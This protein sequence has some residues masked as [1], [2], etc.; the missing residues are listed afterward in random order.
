VHYEVGERT[1]AISQGGIGAV[2]QVA[3]QSGLVSR[4]NQ[5]LHV[6]K[7]HQPYHESDHVLNIAYNIFC[8]GQT[9]D[10]IE[11]RRNDEVYL[12]AL[13][14]MSIPDPTTAGDYCRRFDAERIET[15]TDLVNETRLNVWRRQGPGFTVQTARIDV[16]GSIVPTT[17]ECKEGMGLSYDGTWG[18]HPLLVSL[19]NTSE[20]LFIA[21]RSGNRPSNDGA[22]GYLNRAILLCRRA[23]FVDILL[24]GDTD[25]SQC[26]H[27]DGWTNDGVR[28]VFGYDAKKN[29]KTIA[30]NIDDSEYSRLVRK[31]EEAFEQ[32]AHQPRVKEAFVLAKGYQNLRLRSEEYAEF[33]YRP[34][35][36]RRTYR[37]VVVRK[38]ITVARGEQALFDEIRY[39]FYITNDNDLAARKV[40]KEAND[41]C[42]QENL[43]A[44]LK[45]GVRALHAPLNTL[46]ANWAY[47]V[48]VSLSWSLKAWM[49]LWLPISRRWA[50]QH[51]AQRDAWL[52]MEFRTFCNAVINIPA[53]IVRTGRQLVFRLLAWKPQLPVLFRLLDAL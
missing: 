32:R 19:A 21:N 41:R 20:P 1:K 22:A 45:G 23:G 52:R 50:E 30:E 26:K 16:D 5:Q 46:N 10:D 36:C 7:I 31:A 3:V 43:I 34:N 12:D 47:M 2:H 42:N 25:F 4:L 17:G 13:G 11:Q 15:L 35:A 39:F 51:R 33:E 14:A 6:L 48:M 27:L 53:Q 37:M 49:A 8:G 29:L 18:Y 24:R 44:Q 9:L 40:I 38:N 28:F